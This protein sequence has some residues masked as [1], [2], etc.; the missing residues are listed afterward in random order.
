M[1]GTV[2]LVIA[3]TGH[4]DLHPDDA[5]GFEDG[6]GKTFASLRRSYPNTPLLLLSGLAEGGDRIAV[7]AALK[8][9]VPYIAVLPMPVALYR[10]EFTSEASD[11]E[12]E[13][14]RQG[15]RRS[16]E[17]PL[18]GNSTLDDVSRPGPARDGQYESLGRFLVEYSQIL[19]AIWD[20]DRNATRGG[21]SQ[22]VALKLREEPPSGRLAFSRINA[23]GAG[24]V[25]V[26]PAR[27]A[28]AQ[29][30]VT[31]ALKCE[32]RCPASSSFEAYAASYGLV[33]RFN[34]D[35]ARAGGYFAKSA[36]R[37]RSDLVGGATGLSE[38]MEWVAG[39]YARADALAVHLAA[40]S[41]GIWKAVFILLALSGVALAWLHMMNG[42]PPSLWAYYVC[43]GAAV[44]L[45]LYERRAK[46]P[47]RQED[48]RALA[49]AL[50]VQ[51]FW[52]AAGLRDM[53]AEH[54]LRK[55]AEETVW[56]RD[57]MSECGLYDDVLERSSAGGQYRAARFRLAHTWVAGQASYF[58]NRKRR[59]ERK[60]RALAVFAWLAGGVGL[61]APLVGL[62]VARFEKWS[63][64]TAA[65][66]MWW[67]ALTWTYI[68]RRGFAQEARQYGRMY[69]LFHDA[70]EDLT[71]FEKSEDLDASEEAIRVLGCEAL[72]ESGDWLTMHR[73]RKLP[74]QIAT[75]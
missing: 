12:F 33:D 10:Q 28:G 2:S 22:V 53:A 60:K 29:S 46:R 32:V 34:A 49:E 7:R 58:S 57:A 6:I 68:E 62:F 30:G 35:V 56:I 64:V 48:Y 3:V 37:S 73:E 42:G 41:L 44:G 15:A 39:V 17:L 40:V 52:M 18:A 14:L 38:A 74:V 8:A 66:A 24:P 25:F 45:I 11:A 9:E 71:Q 63:H 36:E 20:Q 23:E 27:R 13:D 31:P 26:L 21:T 51:F 69:R 43:C 4:R 67:A 5:G 75:Q 47:E 59:H 19:I 70:D 65:I 1:T 54:Y 72:A 50:R 61:S 55:Q 16:I